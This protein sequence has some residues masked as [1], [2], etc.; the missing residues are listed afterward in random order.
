MKQADK[1]LGD[2]EALNHFVVNCPELDALEAK[3]GDFNLFEVLG[4]AYAEL[5]HSNTLAWLLNPDES[6]GLGDLFLQRWLMRALHASG[7]SAAPMTPVEIDAWHLVRVEVRREW[8]HIDL[9]LILTLEGGSQWV[10]CIENKVLATQ[11][12]DQLKSYRETVE[13]EF[14][15][16]ERKLYLFLTKN[17][18][19]PDDEAYLSASYEDV[20]QALSEASQMR[21]HTIGREPSV[22]IENYLRLLEEK[23]MNESDIAK[24]ALT[25][26]KKHQRAIDVI[27]AN[28]PENA[29]QDHLTELSRLLDANKERLKIVMGPQSKNYVR[30]IPMEWDIAANRNGKGWR[31]SDIGILFEI[32]ATARG[33]AFMIVAG[34]PPEGWVESLPDECF[35]APFK[36]DAGK[37]SYKNFPRLYGEFVDT[38]DPSEIYAPDEAGE[39]LFTWIE[40][41]LDQDDMRE[42]ILIMAQEIERIP[43]FL[44]SIS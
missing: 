8:R 2:Y 31:G 44:S 25:I 15:G 43:S 13:R 17:N 40:R 1:I 38:Y 19:A 4:V 22:L 35:R 32:E 29:K 12:K 36:L 30:F 16:A 6:H 14:P 42:V 9:L 37:T 26:Y 33:V 34:K 27:V 39:I 10:I 11:S 20:Y 41:R 3:L 7:H 21:R 5:K 23:F 28:M 24:M 18:E